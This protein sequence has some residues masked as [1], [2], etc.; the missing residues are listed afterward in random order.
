MRVYE[1]FLDVASVRNSTDVNSVVETT[2]MFSY[3]SALEWL[4]LLSPSCEYEE[5]I[6]DFD[7]MTEKRNRLQ[8]LFES[9][10]YITDFS[11][12]VFN[13]YEKEY[14]EFTVTPPP[15]VLR[16]SDWRTQALGFVVG[17]E[18]TFRTERQASQ[19]IYQVSSI[20]ANDNGKRQSVDI[21]KSINGKW[22]DPTGR[23]KFFIDFENVEWVAAMNN[24]PNVRPMFMNMF[25][26]K[27]SV[28][29]KSKELLKYL[30]NK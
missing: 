30:Q 18:N 19:F 28:E 5:L 23:D 16:R 29:W 24:V 2:G 4:L 13:V 11:D 22:C 12:I 9:S 20:L 25:Y 3:P 14:D 8:Y 17:F 7:K 6:L 10:K 1:D 21:L 15:F 27:H 26:D